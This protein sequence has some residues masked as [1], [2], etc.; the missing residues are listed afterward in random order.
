MKIQQVMT[1]S[2]RCCR[3]SD[4]L[5]EAARVMWD[6]DCGFV[7]IVDA[8]QR[9]VG[10]LT[11]RD[12]LMAAYTQGERLGELPVSLAMSTPVI[13]CRA[14]DSVTHVE[15]LMREHQVR[16][17]V[18]ADDAARIQGVVT[19]GDLATKSTPRLELA[20]TLAAISE[21]RPHIAAA[22]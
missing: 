2:P 1:T 7:P 4:T 21:A 22:E 13:Q 6:D 9:V 8:E 10:V 20:E 19:L 18:V 3:S 14:E 17:I 11:D 16:R 5:N 12:A 15:R